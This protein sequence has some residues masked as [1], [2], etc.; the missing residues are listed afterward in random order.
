MSEASVRRKPSWLKVRLPQG[1]KY[2]DLKRRVRGLKLNTVC[3][4]ALCP[5]V[6]ECWGRGTC[7]I[8]ILGDICTRACSFCAV[9]SGRPEGLDRAEPERVARAVAESGWRYVVLTSVNRDDLEDGG[10]SIFAECI[11]R[12]RRHSPGTR[13]EVLTPD[14]EGKERDLRTVLEAEP[15]VFAH[16]I[17]VVRRLQKIVRSK[18]TY[19]CSMHVLKQ[20]KEIRPAQIVKSGLQLGHGETEDEVLECFDDLSA[21]GL[22]VLTIGQYLQPTGGGRHREV[23]RYVPPEEFA[24]LGREARARGIRHVFSGPLVRSSYKA[25][26]VFA[27]EEGLGDGAGR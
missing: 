14:F 22:D 17:E 21:V 1:R 7:T 9:T 16:N 13:V 24:R 3:E 6:S 12:I 19:E 8:M 23:R 10:A 27:G 2:V 18:S 25:E 4:E 11:R 5:N 20:A 15:D 26:Q